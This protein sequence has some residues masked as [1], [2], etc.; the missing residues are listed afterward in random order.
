MTSTGFDTISL[1]RHGNNCAGVIAGVANNKFCG[2][3]LAFD[4]K[5]AGKL[6]SLS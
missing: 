2:V 6:Q 1:H 4:A 5:I 3:G